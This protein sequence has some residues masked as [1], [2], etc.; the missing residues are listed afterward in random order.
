MEQLSGRIRSKI[1]PLH[2]SQTLVCVEH[3]H[4]SGVRVQLKLHVSLAHVQF[5]EYCRSIEAILQFFY[6]GNDMSSS[7]D[8]YSSGVKMAG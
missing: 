1:E 4:G 2:S 6:G 3:C 7:L 5:A 8:G